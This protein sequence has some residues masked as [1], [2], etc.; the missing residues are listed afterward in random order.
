MLG[1]AGN[2]S[3]PFETNSPITSRDVNLFITSTS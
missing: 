1:D 3:A 2:V